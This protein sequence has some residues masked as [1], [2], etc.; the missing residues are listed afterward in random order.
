MRLLWV[1]LAV[2][3]V[4]LVNAQPVMRP[5]VSVAQAQRIVAA[6][7]AECSRPGDLVTVSIAVVDRAGQPVM[8]VKADTGHPHNWELSFR[9]AY[10]ARTFRRPT[11]DWKERTAGE[12]PLSG[13]RMLEHVIPVGG[14]VPI[15]MGD[16]PVGAVG[17]TGA[18]GGVDGDEACAQL[19][20]DTVA[21]EFQ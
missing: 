13:Q 9:K 12:S 10:T 5:S 8:Q 1:L 21:D 17:V 6:I 19:G 15:M 3:P 2:L 20:V 11:S 4:A 16:Q 7:I 18:P 14:G